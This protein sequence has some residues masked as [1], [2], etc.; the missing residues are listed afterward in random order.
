MPSR[1]RIRHDGGDAVVP[2][3]VVAIDRIDFLAFGGAVSVRG[4]QAGDFGGP[5]G[6]QGECQD[7]QD[8]EDSELAGAGHR[9]RAPF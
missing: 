7:E 2:Q 8:R 5:A 3:E 9:R 4:V 6:R 1:R